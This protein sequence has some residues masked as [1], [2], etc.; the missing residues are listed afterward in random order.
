M[1][2]APPIFTEGTIFGTV[3]TEL[4]AGIGR[5]S[6]GRG[7]TIVGKG[8]GP[9]A[10]HRRIGT[11][12]MATICI[13]FGASC[14]A[15]GVIDAEGPGTELVLGAGVGT[16]FGEDRG[17]AVIV[18]DGGVVVEEGGGAVVGEG[19]GAVVGATVGTNVANT[20]GPA[21]PWEPASAAV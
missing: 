21:P 5:S 3:T 19:S 2:V 6:G 1:L 12:P 4:T 15:A 10:S 16:G 8:G 7:G 9:D 11:I 20:F 18:A 13:S 17:A 14:G